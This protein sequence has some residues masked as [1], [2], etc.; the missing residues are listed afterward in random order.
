MGDRIRLLLAARTLASKL[1]REFLHVWPVNGHCGASFEDLFKCHEP[2]VTP[3]DPWPQMGVRNYQ[4]IPWSQVLEQLDIISYMQIIKFHCY[5]A[6]FDQHEF[7]M[8]VDFSDQVHTKASEF[9]LHSEDILKPITRGTIGCHV[10]S[11]DYAYKTPQVYE[12][13]K[14]IDSLYAGDG[15]FIYL[16]TDE[17]SVV[18]GFKERYL[19]RLIHYSPSGYQRADTQAT[20]DSAVELCLLRKCGLL[21]LSGWS[22]FSRLACVHQP[23]EYRDGVVTVTGNY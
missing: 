9:A 8:V 19:D 17:P 13:F 3:K 23:P 20:I 6:P 2:I 10:R 11:G 16:A 7:G 4:T 21:V 15:Q 1:G 14:A 12:Y 22:E 5:R 18:K